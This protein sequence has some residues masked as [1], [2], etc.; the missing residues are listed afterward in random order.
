MSTLTW[1]PVPLPSHSHTAKEYYYSFLTQLSS[2]ILLSVILSRP[3]PSIKLVSYSHL[4]LQELEHSTLHCSLHNT[5][6]S[7]MVPPVLV[8]IP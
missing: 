7:P 5:V 1:V 3:L 8:S 6:T 2:R 4:L